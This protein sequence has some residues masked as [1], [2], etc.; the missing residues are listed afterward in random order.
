MFQKSRGAMQPGLLP[1]TGWSTSTSPTSEHTHIKTRAQ[2]HNIRSDGPP[3]T[4]S[5]FQGAS[6]WPDSRLLHSAGSSLAYYLV[7]FYTLPKSLLS[8]LEGESHKTHKTWTHRKKKRANHPTAHLVSLGH[9]ERSKGTTAGC[10]GDRSHKAFEISSHYW[11]LEPQVYREAVNKRLL[12]CF[13]CH[14]RDTGLEK[15]TGFSTTMTVRGVSP[16]ITG[17]TMKESRARTLGRWTGLRKRK[18]RGVECAEE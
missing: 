17:P 1:V 18:H 3:G 6:V 12:R 7:F 10:G 13:L 4:I 9:T 2:K 16:R 14:S 11:Y 5:H 15:N 8:P